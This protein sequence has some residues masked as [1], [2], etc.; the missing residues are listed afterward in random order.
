MHGAS[1]NVKTGQMP[2]L[3]PCITQEGVVGHN[4][5]CGAFNIQFNGGQ[6]TPIPIKSN[7]VALN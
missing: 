4:I 1:F 6:F 3:F 5:V 7:S 2:H